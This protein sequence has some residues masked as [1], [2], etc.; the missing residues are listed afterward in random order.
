MILDTSMRGEEV[1]QI[2]VKRLVPAIADLERSKAMLALLTFFVV[3]SKPDLDAELLKSTV[4]G[5]SEYIVM[6]LTEVDKPKGE[7]N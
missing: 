4:K 5:A 3:L 7:M 6:A 1:E 2:L